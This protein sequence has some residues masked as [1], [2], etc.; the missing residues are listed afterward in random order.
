M[1]KGKPRSKRGGARQENTLA[2]RSILPPIQ[3]NP[4]IRRIFRYE[5]VAVV[6]A[7]ISVLATDLVG[8]M[9]YS[10]GATTSVNIFE[11]VRLKRISIWSTPGG[12][13][14]TVTSSQSVAIDWNGTVGPTGHRVS[15]T[16]LG[17]AYGAYVTSKPPAGS[18]AGFWLDNSTSGNVCQLTVNL[19]DILDFQ[20]EYTLA[21]SGSLASTVTAM[22]GATT[23]RFYLRSP[24]AASSVVQLQP[25]AY[26][27]TN[28][29]S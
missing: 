15:D 2:K 26:P 24:A 16:S 9:V 6:T 13:T 7:P 11:N 21:D 12:T 4:I 5:V 28:S 14:S 29:G 22:V 19:G 25:V 1:A 17:G 3:S 23:G 27:T 10:T 8:L 18:L 20:I